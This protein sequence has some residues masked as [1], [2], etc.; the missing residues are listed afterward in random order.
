MAHAEVG[1]DYSEQTPQNPQATTPSCVR[2]M[3]SA[4]GKEGSAGAVGPPAPGVATGAPQGSARAA[5]WARPS[6]WSTCCFLFTAAPGLQFSPGRWWSLRVERK[7]WKWWLQGLT[8]ASWL[9]RTQKWNAATENGQR[10]HQT[11]SFWDNWWS[12]ILLI[13]QYSWKTPK[14]SYGFLPC[15]L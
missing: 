15:V 11:S 1:S 12:I 14:T 7:V 9:C 3:C 13:Q 6:A 4:G 8:Q 2:K 10:L 5:G